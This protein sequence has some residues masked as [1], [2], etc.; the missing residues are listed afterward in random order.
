MVDLMRRLAVS[1]SQ[2]LRLGPAGI[3]LRATVEAEAKEAA[4]RAIALARRAVAEADQGKLGAALHLLPTA[5]AEAE[6]ATIAGWDW[7]DNQDPNA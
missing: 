3:A 7:L 6:E 4:N 2:A 5:A 1:W